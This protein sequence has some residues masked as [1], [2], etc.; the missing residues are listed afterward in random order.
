MRPFKSVSI[1]CA[2]TNIP[3]SFS[4]TNTA[5]RVLQGLDNYTHVMLIHDTACKLIMNTNYDAYAPADNNSSNVYVWESTKM[6]GVVADGVSVAGSVYL[7]GNG[8]A[9]A[10]GT[11][12]VVVW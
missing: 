5:S 3:P 12:T 7:R 4:A 8:G 2:A 9:C 1:N 10:A 6:L 11:V